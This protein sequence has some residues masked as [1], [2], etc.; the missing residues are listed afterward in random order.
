[1]TKLH[2]L[3]AQGQSV[4]FDFIRR[5]LLTSGELKDL[6]DRGVRGVTSNPSIFEQAIARNDDYDEALREL[7]ARGLDTQ[8][9]YE[10]L[11]IDDI[12]HACDILRP[13][14]DGSKASDGHVSLEVSPLLAHDTEGTVAEA[15]RL[16]ATVDRPNL[17]IK[18]PVTPAGV[19]AIEAL[20]ADGINVNVTLIFSLAH[21][22]ATAEAYIRGLERRAAA[23]QPLEGVASVASF[24]VSRLDTAV[25]RQLAEL[26]RDDLLGKTA[27][28]NARVAY[29][30]FQELFAGERWNAL[31]AAGAQVQRV[32]W[33]STGT[34]D[35]AYPDTLYVDELIG[36]DTVNTV[37]PKTLD[38]FFDHGTVARTVDANLADAR[39]R[40]AT[41]ATLAIDVGA[42][43]EDL[44]KAGVDSF[45]AAFESLLASIEAK[46][47]DL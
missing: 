41:L 29:A 45:A 43:T 13:V 47:G 36:P 32:L 27:V 30:R 16:W 8:T 42:V 19:P 11:A 33:A 9:I 26:G 4:W 14:F 46:R 1:M 24:F 12:R 40:L 10:T 20:I 38:A 28:D 31:A 2:D 6:V 44:Q 7:V 23:G 22:E 3:H 34:K 18:V 25:D 17:M 35:P 39:T 21:Y 15:R 5:A 37:P